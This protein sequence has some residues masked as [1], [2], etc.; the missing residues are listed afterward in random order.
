[1]FRLVISD[2]A[3]I[4]RNLIGLKTKKIYNKCIILMKK[5]SHAALL[6]SQ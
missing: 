4:V 3:L 1:M 2:S 6:V 5:A